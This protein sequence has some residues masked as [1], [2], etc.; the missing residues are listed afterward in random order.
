MVY[1]CLFCPFDVEIGQRLQI[2]HNFLQKKFFLRF[3]VTFSPSSR[4]KC[5]HLT[6]EMPLFNTK[7]NEELLSQLDDFDTIV[8]ENHR[9]VYSLAL[10]I[11]GSVVEAEDITQEVFF[12]LYRSRMTIRGA[13][14][15]STLLYRMT[16]NL[17]VDFVRKRKIQR[18]EL[19]EDLIA[20]QSEEELNYDEKMTILES[21]IAQL[22]VEDRVII[23]LFYS[24]HRS[25]DEISS[26]VNLS[27]ANIKTKLH[28]IRRKL[29]DIVGEKDYEQ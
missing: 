10:R 20:K 7:P 3:F 4:Q 24:D 5:V 13:S 14:K 12:K 27:R 17:S 29:H 26:I 16:Y 28:R 1:N 11:V 15:M 19:R 25:I 6:E 18:C 8:A 9:L 21:A 22:D 23:T 2:T